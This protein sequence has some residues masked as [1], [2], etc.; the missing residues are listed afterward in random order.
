MA[1][2]KNNQ[3]GSDR[4]IVITRLIDAPLE[5]V[6]RAWADPKE[7]VKWWGPHGFSNETEKR[8]FKSG[9]FWK[10]VMIGPDGGRYQNLARYEE[11]VEKE[12]LVYTN[13][14][15][16]EGSGDGVHFR[17]TV[18]FKA[19]G[20]KTEITMRS[21]FDTPAERDHVV[22]V[23]R[24]VEGGHQTL[25]RLDAHV[26]GNFVMSR[27]VDAPR[28]RVWKAW[29]DPAELAKWFGPKGF[30]TFHAQLDLRPGGTYHYGIKGNGVEM[31]GKWTFREIERP[32]KLH[33]VQAFSDK[34]GGLGVH[35]LAP[36]WPKQTLSTIL[37]QDFGPKTLITVYWAPFEASEV[38][39]KT[40]RD[41]MAGMNQ[42]WSGTWERL[43]AYLKERK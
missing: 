12:K 6:W 3:A 26:R 28:E 18:T 14:G 11:V 2:L 20:D 25:S 37:F 1:T 35:P 17:A 16:R 33:F 42:G 30:E 27:L 13:G 41:G 38:E 4:E 34:D 31:W 29:T 22:K 36:T 19:V 43:D 39:L 7:I 40:F 24:A 5:R 21:V 8:E 23:Y 10:H 32:A 15:E 9:G